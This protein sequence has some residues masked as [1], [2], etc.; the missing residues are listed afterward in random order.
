[1]FDG[2]NCLYKLTDDIIRAALESFINP[3]DSIDSDDELYWLKLYYV[4]PKLDPEEINEIL[5]RKKQEEIK[6]DLEVEA[7]LEAKSDPN[8]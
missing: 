4:I 2:F 6:L 1:M 3:Q 5:D 7:E 8:D